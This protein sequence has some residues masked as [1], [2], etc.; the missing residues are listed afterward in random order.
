MLIR[1]LL[2]LVM[3]AGIALSAADFQLRMNEGRKAYVNADYAAAMLAFAEARTDAD[4][5][6]MG[7]EY[8]QAGLWHAMAAH[9]SGRSVLARDSLRDVFDFNDQP[10]PDAWAMATPEF[11]E[12]YTTAGETRFGRDW[13]DQLRSTNAGTQAPIIPPDPAPAPQTATPTPIVP[14]AAPANV[15]QQ[16]IIDLTGGQSRSGW[17]RVS[18]GGALRFGS[19]GI[20]NDVDSNES[21]GFTEFAIIFSH[22]PAPF[23]RYAAELAFAGYS[24]DEV[25]I[26]VA[27]GYGDLDMD[28]VSIAGSAFY[29]M[30]MD[31]RGEWAFEF[32]GSFG[33]EGGDGEWT[34]G[35]TT[36]TFDV[37]GVRGSFEGAFTMQPT[38]ELRL[39]GSAGL[40]IGGYDFDWDTAPVFTET[41]WGAAA[42]Y[43]GLEAGFV[44]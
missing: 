36:E 21:G 43:L 4:A 22:Q 23:F 13:A 28:T 37:S 19:L 5:R 34:N 31:N 44:F 8:A 10:A 38:R 30:P 39:R 41:D 27:S 3:T 17:D 24:A 29:I 6:N 20:G 14:T 11:K 32:G 16:Q 9:A 2:L 42:L 7:T 12:L 26:S 15:G 1:T 18:I 33:F 40:R 25:P 35:G